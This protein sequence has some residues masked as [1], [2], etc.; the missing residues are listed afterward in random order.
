MK[1]MFCLCI[2]SA[3]LTACASQQTQDVSAS[4]SVSYDPAHYA[5]IRLFGQNQ[6]PSVMNVGKDC[7]TGAKGY[8][9][10]V[11]GGFGDAFKSF[12]GAASNKSLGIPETE[13]T[14]QLSAR[15]GLLSKAFYQE[16][17]IPAGTLVRVRASY[18][19][20]TTTSSSPREIIISR[21]KSSTSRDVP[22]VPQAGKDYEAISTRQNNKEFVWIYEV[23][24]DGTL[25]PIP[26]KQ[27]EACGE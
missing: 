9:V 23:K 4:V 14:R 10:N 13:S 21:E 18:I 11:G 19:G 12:A 17:V 25:Q 2:F 16:F 1:K 26:E 8:K 3:L 7:A 22:F 20:L 15:D 5:R 24:T 6:R 27:P